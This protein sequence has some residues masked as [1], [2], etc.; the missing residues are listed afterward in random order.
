MKS[1]LL[2][3]TALVLVAG[4][5]AADGHSSITWSGTATAGVARIGNGEKA[6][7]AVA[8]T[9]TGAQ[10]AAYTL[11]EVTLATVSATQFAAIFCQ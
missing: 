6:I 8:T 2:T 11:A 1:I 10:Y 5:A 9:A 3:S 7:A 4:I